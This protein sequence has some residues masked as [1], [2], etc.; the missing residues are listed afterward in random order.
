MGM[1]ELSLHEVLSRPT[2]R[3]GYAK[4]KEEKI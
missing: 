2:C 3:T 1:E 4:A